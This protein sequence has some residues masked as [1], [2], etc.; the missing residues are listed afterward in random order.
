MS[1]PVQQHLLS[2]LSTF[3][4]KNNPSFRSENHKFS[5]LVEEDVFFW[6][7]ETWRAAIQR[8]ET[9][10]SPNLPR[11]DCWL[12]T[13]APNQ[14]D[15]YPRIK[16]AGKA[17]ALHRFVAVL[18]FPDRFVDLVKHGRD[19]QVG[20]RCH[21]SPQLCFNPSHFRL[22]GDSENKDM[23]K[24]VYGLAALCPHSPKCLWMDRDGVPLPCRNRN[25]VA[26]C[27][28]LQSGSCWIG[29]GRKQEYK[30][31]TVEKRES[32]HAGLAGGQARPRQAKPSQARPSQAKPSAQPDC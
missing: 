16:V 2:L 5:K 15:G 13:F 3:L 8:I 28:C 23:T 29:T 11:G 21:H 32:A 10:N 24:C 22:V 18:A 17:V 1:S 14:A 30:K 9:A 26:A 6:R 27:T 31:A 12:S 19:L 20:H 4:Q 7:E 25:T